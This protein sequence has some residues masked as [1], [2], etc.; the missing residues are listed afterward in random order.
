MVPL[1]A[2]LDEFGNPF[3]FVSI[4]TE[5][6]SHVLFLHFPL[7]SIQPSV[8]CV[9]HDGYHELCRAHARRFGY[10]E[11]CCNAENLIFVRRPRVAGFHRPRLSRDAARQEK[12]S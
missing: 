11:V 3:D 4:D 12:Q 10:R 1:E 5:G 2:L 8:V 9:E 7:A 6:T